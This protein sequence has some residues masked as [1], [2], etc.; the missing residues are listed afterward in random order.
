MLLSVIIPIYNAESSLRHCLRSIL[1]Q[2]DE[3]AEV[4]CID[5]GSSDNSGKICDEIA[6]EYDCLRVYHKA[7]G[8]VSSARNL[9]LSYAHGTYI[10]WV[11]SDDYVADNWYQSLKPLMERGIHLILFEH[12]RVENGTQKR[13]RYC[14]E[15]MFIDKSIFIHDLVLDIKLQSY[16]WDKVFKRRLFTNILF[17]VDISLMEDYSILH[18]VCDRARTIYYLARPLYYYVIRNDSISHTIDLQD[19][20]QTVLIAK[21]R[22]DWLSKRYEGVSRAGYLKNCLIFLACVLR[23]GKGDKWKVEYYSCRSDICN[24]IISLLLDRDIPFKYKA[25]YCMVYFNVIKLFY[26]MRSKMKQGGVVYDFNSNYLI[27]DNIFYYNNTG[28]VSVC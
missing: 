21:K 1:K 5:D 3:E 4:I 23:S 16:L 17:P 8:G 14:K 22:Y 28:S 12:Y 7:N 13:V 2:I 9:A 24:H 27:F 25:K 15:S 19:Q 18:K 11:D 10:A 6:K 20:Y 26:R